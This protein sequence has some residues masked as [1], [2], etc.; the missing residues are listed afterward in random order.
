MTAP[1]LRERIT[2]LVNY[3][4]GL[5]AGNRAAVASRMMAPHRKLFDPV[6]FSERQRALQE[7][8]DM[9]EYYLRALLVDLEEST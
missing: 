4:N 2:R 6:S 5:S 9:P 7:A 8:L 1:Q 3:V